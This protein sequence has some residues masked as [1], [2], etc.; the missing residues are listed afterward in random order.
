[1]VSEIFHLRS[2]LS[3]IIV[4][5]SKLKFKIWEGFNKLVLRYF[6]F[7]ILRLNSMG[8]HLYLRYLNILHW[9]PKSTFKFWV[10]SNKRLLRYSSFNISKL[11]SIGGHLHLKDLKNMVWSY[12]LK[13]KIW[14]D[15][16]SSFGDIPLLIFWGRLPWEVIFIWSVLTLCFCCRSLSLKF[17]YD[18]KTVA[19]IFHF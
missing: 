8:G 7:N 3:Y 14:D 10:W 9:S 13:F 1:M 16:I 2:S 5:S 19:E 12:K 18:P 11:F 6:T 4:W 17:E 15:P